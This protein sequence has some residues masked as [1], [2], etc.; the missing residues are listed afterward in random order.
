MRSLSVRQPWADLI[1]SGN[2]TLEIRSWTPNLYRGP[3]LICASSKRLP[4]DSPHQASRYGVA[5]CIVDLIGCRTFAEA[6]EARA[7]CDREPGLYAWE[8]ANPRPVKPVP[9][10]GRLH[11]FSVPG[12]LI[13][14]I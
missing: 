1:A 14:L 2:K 10:K 6:D 8:L 4:K 7:C 9:I 11:L 5:V 12:D 13:E 3:L